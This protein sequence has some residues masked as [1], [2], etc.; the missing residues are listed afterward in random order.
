MNLSKK[1]IQFIDT[2]LENS[3][4]VHIDIRLEMIDHVASKIES[5]IELGDSRDFYYIFKDYMIKHKSKL[6]K[7]NR[8]FLRAADAKVL[9]LLLKTLLSWQSVLVFFTM[10]TLCYFLLSKVGS[11]L[12][13]SWIIGLPIIGFALFGLCYI[14]VLK[15]FRLDRF[16]TV[17]RIGLVCNGFFQIL[18]LIWLFSQQNI[19]I[20]NII[21]IAI[22]FSL[23]MVF[24]FTLT[25]TTITL[26]KSYKAN[27]K[28]LA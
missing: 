20:Q 17:E 21:Y 9:R 16:S 22:G 14:L 23:A 3:D 2:Y 8:Q 5:Q 27:F 26:I 13:K 24:L 1:E 19:E 4:V 10:Y 6:L 11:L 15:L 12:L 18:Y 25:K 28:P 7:N